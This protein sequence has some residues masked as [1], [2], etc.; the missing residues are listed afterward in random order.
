MFHNL[1][2]G[3]QVAFQP[4]NLLFSALGV[5]LG[6]LV[7]VLP[8]IGPVGAMALLLPAT[9][10]LS[11]TA[12]LI[13]L[14]GIW[15]GSQYGGST[16]SILVNIPGEATS[17]M[18][19]IDGYQ[20]SRK[21]R[22]GPALAMA[23]W[24]SFIAGTFSI[25]GLMALAVPLGEQALRFGPPEYFSLMCAGLVLLTFMA[26]KSFLKAIMM[27]AVGVLL[28][29]VGL[30]LISG[31]PRFTFGMDA[32]IDGI[33]ISPMVM[34]LFGIAEILDSLDDAAQGIV[35]SGAIGRLYPSVKDWVKAKWSII[36]GTVI[37]FVLGILPGGGAILSTFVAYGV[38]KKFSKTPE[39]FGHGAIEGVA[40]PE[41]SNN[42]AAESALIPL[43]SLGI[44]PN[45]NMAMLF[46]ALLIH[47]IQPG[48]LLI[49]EHPDIFWGLIASLYVG[50]ILLL[51]LNLPLVG[52]WVRVLKIP[53]KILFPL[54]LLFCLIGAYSI[55]GMIFD[56]YVMLFFGV[57]GYLSRKFGY[58]I[59]P[60]VLAFV[61]G[62]RLEQSLRQSLLMSEG[63]FSIF[64]TSPLSAIA[65][66]IAVLLLISN[67]VPG[68][69]RG[70]QLYNKAK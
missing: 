3:F 7:G 25:V 39:E 45:V 17:V 61:L 23:A 42:A 33:S 36:R 65:L 16:T 46:S 29:T 13:M 37:G 11:P 56:V 30:D 28:S 4:D 68:L 14:A 48:P 24:A 31:L 57:I 43:L 70:R 49:K 59:A 60:L 44:P 27:A 12:S 40:G 22:A 69:K 52:I 63:S 67:F 34:G 58:E 18:T 41:A 19:C 47:G 20:M 10:G 54:I 35:F 38:E 2:F 51:V 26:Q 62:G 9:F 53:Q 8:G 5:L 1:I 15:Y 55:N 50:N 6:T 32:L 66:G 21:G 64:F